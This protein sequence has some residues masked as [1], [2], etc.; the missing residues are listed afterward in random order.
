MNKLSFIAART[1]SSRAA[2]LADLLA[3]HDADFV[4]CAFVTVLAR[5]PDAQ[6]EAYYTDLIRQ[7]RSK[8][9]VLWRLRRSPEGLANDPGIAGF[10]RALKRAAWGRR[11]FLGAPLRM[12]AGIEGDSP[13]DRTRPERA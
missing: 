10:D 13:A 7:G 1:P 8:L 4:R 9:D 2:S 6:G 3:W 5:Q 11:R 12:L